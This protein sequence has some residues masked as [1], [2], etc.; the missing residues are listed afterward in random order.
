[1]VVE[2]SAFN[3]HTALGTINIVIVIFAVLCMTAIFGILLQVVNLKG[4]PKILYDVYSS[5][6]SCEVELFSSLVSAVLVPKSWF[7]HFYVFATVYTFLIVIVIIW[8]ILTKNQLPFFISM[9]INSLSAHSCTTIASPQISLLAT[10]LFLLQVSRR[11]YESM[12]VTVF[13]DSKMN[14]GH[15][16]VGHFHYW[17]C[18]TILLSYAACQSLQDDHTNEEAKNEIHLQHVIGTVL[19]IIT[20]YQQYIAHNT[21]ANLRKKPQNKQKYGLPQGGLFNYVSCPNFLCEIIIYLAINLVL[22]IDFYPWTL[23]TFWVLT[24]QVMAATVAQKW[25]KSKFKEFPA[26]RKALIPFVY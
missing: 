2:E 5:G 6:K 4:M 3:D 18:G 23:I 11:A 15:Y 21:L 20:F 17:G 13:L 9:Y 14:L 25:Y 1:M 16:I 10:S 8:M 24:N 22:G 12:Y 26:T 19:F 7:F